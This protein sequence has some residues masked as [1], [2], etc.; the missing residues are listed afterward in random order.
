M[1]FTYTFYMSVQ[2]WFFSPPYHPFWVSPPYN[3]HNY[4]AKSILFTGLKK[5]PHNPAITNGGE[6]INCQ[7]L[8][9]KAFQ[10]FIVFRVEYTS[11]RW[12]G[13]AH[14]NLKIQH[15]S[16][17]SW[18]AVWAVWMNKGGIEK[19]REKESCLDLDVSQR[20][21]LCTHW[22]ERP[23][24]HRADLQHLRHSKHSRSVR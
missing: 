5:K 10:H 13:W 2:R 7:H 22:A 8:H 3:Q 24:V 17:R 6:T 19:E 16:I 4:S 1:L 23:A 11:V 15:R 21:I 14:S 12:A 18:Q 9:W 20:R